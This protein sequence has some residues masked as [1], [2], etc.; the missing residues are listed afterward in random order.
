MPGEVGPFEELLA[1]PDCT[2]A[3]R[4]LTCTA[5][6]ER[7]ASPDGIPA[8][9]RAGDA[10][11]ETV[12]AF[13]AQAPFPGYDPGE[14]L[15]TLRSRARRSAFARCLDDA[16]PAHARVLEVGCGT[17]QMSLFL[18]G[19]DRVIVAADIA[20][21]SLELAAGA[22]R[23]FGIDRALF[24][25]TD[26]RRPGLRRAAFD[27][28]YSS[29]VLHHTPDPRRS[30]AALASLVKPGGVVVLGLY[31]SFARFPH[32]LRRGAARLTR[33][34]LIP[35]DPIL[36]ARSA[37]PERRTAWF[38]DQY[39]HPEEHRHT[40]GEVQRWFRENGIAYLR[41]YPSALLGTDPPDGWELFTPA[42][43]DWGPE[44]LV[45]QLAWMR[46]LAAEGG[47]FVTIGRRHP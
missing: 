38:R 36:T 26:L 11:T 31:N 23:R 29:G 3:L 33:Y 16:I 17:G 12:R 2:G 37:T 41:A 1:C 18:S 24:V 22:A 34:R 8:L 13:Y 47:L 19:A 35:F 40:L 44:H 14:T 21:P 10:R 9:L 45:S 25:E 43:D 6:G 27:V 5:C 4:A 20:R 28:V 39:R 32:R 30:F 42:E 7:Y 46:T 15:A